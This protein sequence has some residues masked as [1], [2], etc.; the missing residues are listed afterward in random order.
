M[1]EPIS[2]ALQSAEFWHMGRPAGSSPT[3]S[4]TWL[5]SCWSFSPSSAERLAAERKAADSV[6]QEKT[7]LCLSDAVLLVGPLKTLKNISNWGPL[8]PNK[9]KI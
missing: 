8:K 6:P 2:A 5:W 1:A 3:L 9:G 4:W 7:S